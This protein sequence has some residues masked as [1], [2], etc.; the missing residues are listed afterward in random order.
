MRQEIGLLLI[1][2]GFLLVM[3]SILQNPSQG[4]S[5]YGGGDPDRADTRRLRIEP[6]DGHNVYDRCIWVDGVDIPSFQEA[7]ELDARDS[8]N[9]SDLHW[10][11]DVNLAPGE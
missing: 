7:L 10:I 9:C 1:A 3:L 6:G 4:N 8:G 11:Y 5:G 2:M